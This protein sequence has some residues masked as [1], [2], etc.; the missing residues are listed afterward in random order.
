MR[1]YATASDS[2]LS[3]F[4]INKHFGVISALV[5]SLILSACGGGGG[6]GNAGPAIEGA[7]SLVEVSMSSGELSAVTVGD[8]VTVTMSASEAIRAPSVKIGGVSVDRVVG[9]GTS[10]TADRVMTADDS[11]GAVTLSIT[12]EDIGGEAGTT[13]TATTDGSALTMEINSESGNVVDGPFQNALAFADYDNDGVLDV[14]EPSA[15]TDANGAYSLVKDASAPS[16]F[17]IVVQMTDTTI[18]SISGESYAGTGVVL[19]AASGGSVV[20]PV[21]TMLEAAKAADPSYTA[22]DLALAMGL[23]AGVDIT[24]YNPFDADADAA[25]AHAV[26]KVF[27]QVMTATLVVAEAMA[28][29]GDI[30]GVALTPEE[31]AAAALS[32]VANMV[33][34]TAAVDLADSTQLASVQEKAKD[35]LASAGVTVDEAVADFVLGKAADTVEQVSDAIQALTVADFGSSDAS[36]VSLLKHDAKA[37]LAAMAEAAA[38][39]LADTSN[40]DLS[41]FDSAATLTLDTAAGV[42]AEQAANVAVVEAYVSTLGGTVEGWDMFGGAEIDG[43]VFTF[44]T[45][46]EVWAG[47]ANQTS[48]LYPFNFSIGGTITFNASIPAGA[49]PVNV[50]FTFENAPHPD[51]APNFSVENVTVDSTTD[52]TYRVSIPAQDPDQLYRSF[53]MYVVERDA[54]VTVCNVQVSIG[55][56]VVDGIPCAGGDTD[57]NTD[58]DTDTDTG[59]TGGTGA[60]VTI[61]LPV[62]FEQDAA[63]YEIEGF[64]GGTATVE[65]APGGGK[66]LKYVK[67]ADKNWG[68]VWVNLDTAVDPSAGTSFTARVHSTVA[69]DVTFKFDAAN[70]E[71]AVKTAGN[72]WETLTFDFG[73]DTPT[74][75]T[76]I[77]FFNDLTMLGDGSEDWTIYI[78]DLAQVGSGSGGDADA[79]GS[80]NSVATLQPGVIADFN[81]AD[82]TAS[83]EFIQFG[84]VQDGESPNPDSTTFVADPADATNTVAKTTKKTTSQGWAGVTVTTADAVGGDASAPVVFPLTATNSFVSMRVYAPAAGMPIRM[85]FEDASDSTKSVEAEVN[86]AVGN[87]WE[88][89]YFDFSN[90]VEGT[91]ALNEST[92]YSKASIFFNFSAEQSEDLEFYWDSLKWIGEFNI[93]PT[94]IVPGS[95][96]TSIFSDG[97]ADEAGTDFTPNWGQSTQISVVDGQLVY[98]NLNY[99]GIVLASSVD[100]SSDDYVHVDIYTEDATALSL[101]LINP[102]DPA[103]ET[104][105]DLSSSLVLNQWVSVDIPLSA[106]AGV[107]LETVGQLK[108]VGDGTVTIDNLY[109]VTTPVPTAAPADPEQDAAN[110]I[111]IFGDTYTNETVT[112]DGTYSGDA[113]TTDS[114]HAIGSGSDVVLRY[115]GMSYAIMELGVIDASDMTHLHLDVWASDFTEF[116][117][118]IVDTTNP[119]PDTTEGAVVLNAASNPALEVAGWVSLDIK[120]A[121]LLEAEGG[122]ASKAHIGELVVEAVGASGKTLILDNIYFYKDVSGPSVVSIFSDKYEDIAGTD[123]NPG[124][125]QATQVDVDTTAGEITYTG[126]NYQGTQFTNTDVSEYEYVNVEYYSDDATSLEFFLISSG[127]GEETAYDLAP[128]MQV[129]EWNSIQIPLSHF[130]AVDLTDVFQF[131]VVGDGAVKFRNWHFGGSAAS[132]LP[133]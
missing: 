114:A 115:D 41:G 48:S 79:G 112:Y 71:R 68:G 131:K 107:D 35:E 94:P 103:V 109:F 51:N 95:Y 25:T 65:A 26:E 75:N 89:L 27:Q 22:A 55:D 52:T 66:A 96:V 128:A 70:V 28:G 18:D 53:L 86:T 16:S 87:A 13:V 81:D 56:D 84:D 69:R 67:G 19:K 121:D 76:K 91:A 132:L 73:S 110:V 116:K 38:T 129:G 82:V 85:K 60:T 11:A 101:F 40:T 58:T 59:G 118:K 130:T 119:Y 123:F 6:G 133:E 120:L 127:E 90:Q 43:D 49:D 106:F 31:A 20:T 117:V 45:G 105:Y 12:F 7:P 104:E 57:T 47:Y 21:T 93:A 113:V 42:A 78:D 30:A 1:S 125:G 15:T 39:H 63:V 72:G 98:A 5:F 10:W 111:S 32:A 8:K 126:L 33:V 9:S 99:A 64:D 77:A 80:D 124:W 92:T 23:P 34:E 54:P 46:A 100:V 2:W 74:G 37:Q 17:N 61:A 50:K 44:P 122:L 29:L 4:G 97:Y 24:T 14:G 102:G 83:L 88:T 108:V 62:D 36:S 3:I